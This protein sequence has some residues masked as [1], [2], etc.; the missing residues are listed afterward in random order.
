MMKMWTFETNDRR[1]PWHSKSIFTDLYY[2]GV[3]LVNKR[4][5]LLIFFFSLDVLVVTV[6]LRHDERHGYGDQRES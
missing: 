5:Y 3:K 4:S 1:Q 6:K 2:A